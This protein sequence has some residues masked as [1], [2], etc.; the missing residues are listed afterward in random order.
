[1][2]ISSVVISDDLGST[3]QLIDGWY[4]SFSDTTITAKAYGI[5]LYWKKSLSGTLDLDF[6]TIID[7]VTI[8]RSTNAGIY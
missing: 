3:I 1:M 7:N 4:Q 8:T 2:G 6:I 5:Y